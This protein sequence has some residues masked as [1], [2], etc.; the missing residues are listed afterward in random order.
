MLGVDVAWISGMKYTTKALGVDMI[1]DHNHLREED[2]RH[3]MTAGTSHGQGRFDGQ[4]KSKTSHTV[5]SLT[6]R[7]GSLTVQ[8]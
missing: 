8:H 2:S 1:I 7:F 5:N 4:R 3:P 6:F